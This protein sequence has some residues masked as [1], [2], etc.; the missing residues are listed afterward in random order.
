[1]SHPATLNDS[2]VRVGAYVRTSAAKERTRPTSLDVQAQRCLQ[3]C[4]QLYGAGGYVATI[5]T[6]RGYSGPA[7]QARFDLA[8]DRTGLAQLRDAI[9]RGD[10]RAVV[11]S[12]PDRLF[13]SPVLY[14]QFVEDLLRP[15]GM[16]LISAS[17]A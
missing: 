8:H 14:R 6:D 15:R 3:Q 10:V 11:V 16:P 12:S 13:R 5:F 1:M 2:P 17:A 9:S 4:E 7:P